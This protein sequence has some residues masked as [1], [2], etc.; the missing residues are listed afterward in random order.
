M[1][2]STVS[3]RIAGEADSASDRPLGRE[4]VHTDNRAAD[5][6]GEPFWKRHSLSLVAGGV[7]V[8]L[9]KKLIEPGSKESHDEKEG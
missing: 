4:A 8:L 9:T 1:P 6:H 3:Q 7:L 5:H 2:E